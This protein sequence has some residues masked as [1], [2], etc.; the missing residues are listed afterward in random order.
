MKSLSVVENINGLKNK[1]EQLEKE[2]LR[3][4]GSIIILETLVKA[5]IKD[6]AIPEEED[7]EVIDE[8]VVQP[9]NDT[10]TQ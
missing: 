1:K 4:E 9:R 10:D 5:G 7:K 3:L 8:N 2:V 6:I